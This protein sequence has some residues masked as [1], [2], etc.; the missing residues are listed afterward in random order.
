MQISLRAGERIYVN[1]AVL[2]FDR[3]VTMELLND[4]T[5]LL[6][7]HVLHAEQAT[8]PLRQLYFIM[9]TMLVE[10][11]KAAEARQMFEQLHELLCTSFE[12]AHVLAELDRVIDLVSTD[13]VFE[14]LKTI[15][16]LFPIEDGILAGAPSPAPATRKQTAEA[17]SCK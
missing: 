8:T 5:F 10:P 12:N 15:R 14:A 16:A 6:E 9:Q 17:G 13:K 2:R 4:V 7:T 3:K 1:G 11:A